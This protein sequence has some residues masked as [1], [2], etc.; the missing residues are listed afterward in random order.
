MPWFAGHLA[1]RLALLL[2]LRT[3]GVSNA[4]SAGKPGVFAC[5]QSGQRFLVVTYALSPI[6]G[7]WS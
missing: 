2:S 6:G 5:P 4:A 1:L 3:A 7:F